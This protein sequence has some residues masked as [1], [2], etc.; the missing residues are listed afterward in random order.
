MGD[1]RKPVAGPKMTSPKAAKIGI[2]TMRRI[3]G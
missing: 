2:A 3:E 1:A